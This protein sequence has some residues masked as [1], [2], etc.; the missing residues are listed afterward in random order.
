MLMYTIAFAIVSIACW[1][2]VVER[3]RATSIKVEYQLEL[4]DQNTVRMRN[5]HSGRVYETT[6]DSIIYYLETDNM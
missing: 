2:K 1:F 3:P 5:I 4:V 6:P